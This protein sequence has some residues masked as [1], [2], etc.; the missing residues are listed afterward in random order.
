MSRRKHAWDAHVEYGDREAVE[1]AVRA[2]YADDVM[3]RI[4]RLSELAERTGNPGVVL[5]LELALD[6][7][8]E[9]RRA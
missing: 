8:L 3:E 4:G 1:E 2:D 6:A 5:G 7:I 9:A